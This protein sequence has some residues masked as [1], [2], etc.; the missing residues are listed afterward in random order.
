LLD[1]LPTDIDEGHEA[2]DSIN[3]GR[4]D[5]LDDAWDEGEPLVETIDRHIHANT[6]VFFA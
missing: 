3:E 1:N 4:L 2:I 6:S 5:G